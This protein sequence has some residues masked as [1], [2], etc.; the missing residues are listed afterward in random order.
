MEGKG[1][2]E[3]LDLYMKGNYD[4]LVG[5]RVRVTG[6]RKHPKSE[7][8]KFLLGRTG[9]IKGWVFDNQLSCLVAK[10]QMDNKV[11]CFSSEVWIEV[12]V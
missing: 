6:V 4:D 12:L 2:K 1:L 7:A 10:V 9:I 8:R 5:F 11:I 3:F